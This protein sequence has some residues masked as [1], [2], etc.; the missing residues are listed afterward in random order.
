MGSNA[1]LGLVLPPVTAAL[2]FRRKGLSPNWDLPDEP[3]SRLACSPGPPARSNISGSPCAA[4]APSSSSRPL[5]PPPR[6]RA[7]T[8]SLCDAGAS[9]VCITG[10]ACRPSAAIAIHAGF[11]PAHQWD[12]RREHASASA[13]PFRSLDMSRMS[14]KPRHGSPRLCTNSVRAQATVSLG[15]RNV[16]DET[17]TTRFKVGKESRDHVTE[18]TCKCRKNHHK[19]VTSSMNTLYTWN[20]NQNKLHSK[21]LLYRPR[22]CTDAGS[23]L[24]PPRS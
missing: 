3:W 24:P 18:H 8:T 4:S 11:K 21:T 16:V 5:S 2:S 15:P 23:D 7:T 9:V 17:A 20:R 10:T 12:R 14:C 22:T 6:R 13:S 1:S 19:A